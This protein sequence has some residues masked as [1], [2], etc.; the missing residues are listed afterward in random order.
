M[1]KMIAESLDDFLK[2]KA[3]NNLNESLKGSID[4]FLK[5]PKDEKQANV[6]LGQAFAKQFAAQEKTKKYIFSLKLDDKNKL[7]SQCAKKLENSAIGILKIF[8]NAMGKLVVGGTP[9]S[10]GASQAV[11]G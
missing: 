6:L 8:K 3:G 9:V 1:K 2:V 10:G 5:N 7:L 4:I 11:K